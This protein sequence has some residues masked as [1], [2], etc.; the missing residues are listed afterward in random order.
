MISVSL[1]LRGYQVIACRSLKKPPVGPFAPSVAS[2]TMV[3][4]PSCTDLGA[5]GPPM[6]VRTQ[7]GHALF[8]STP[9]PR[10]AAA[11]CRVK[12]LSAALDIEYAGAY[13]PIDASCPASDDTLTMRP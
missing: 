13:G 7:P 11:S 12:A 1:C 5:P 2:Q 8:T 4:A 9:E 6:S 3:S 10:M